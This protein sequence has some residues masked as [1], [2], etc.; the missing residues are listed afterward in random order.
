MC[1]FADI[2][3]YARNIELGDTQCPC[4]SDTPR[5]NDTL[6][7]GFLI[8]SSIYISVPRMIHIIV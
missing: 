7:S 3:D 2:P 4:V 8:I 6:M 1:T 5:R